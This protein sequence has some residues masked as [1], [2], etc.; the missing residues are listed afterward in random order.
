MCCGRNPLFHYAY[1]R[2]GSS[3]LKSPPIDVEFSVPHL[4]E[5]RMGFPS[6][7]ASGRKGARQVA[8]GLVV[9]ATKLGFSGLDSGYPGNRSAHLRSYSCW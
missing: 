6:G 1:E 5:T 9:Q 8:Q 3:C 2:Y 7:A 4:L